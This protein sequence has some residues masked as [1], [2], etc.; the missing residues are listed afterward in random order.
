MPWKD[1]GVAVSSPQSARYPSWLQRQ[2]DPSS[3]SFVPGGGG[4]VNVTG[5]N[6]VTLGT[7]ARAERAV[8][9]GRG[10]LTPTPGELGG[11]SLDWWIG[12]EDRW[13]LPSQEVS[14]RQ[15]LVDDAPVVETSM[16]IRGGDVVHRA[17]AIAAEDGTPWV[18]V[19]V[20]NRTSSAVAV[21]AV[22]R[23]WGPLGPARVD[24]VGV[25]GAWVVVDGRA[26]VGLPQPP[27][28]TYAASATDATSVL[29]AAVAASESTPSDGAVC[30][31]GRAELAAV[32]PLPHTLVA[33]F[34]VPL[35]PAAP[36]RGRVALPDLPATLP[37]AAQVASGWSAQAGRGVAVEVPDATIAGALEANRRHLL[38]VAAGEDLVT[39]P[40]VAD[41][42][43]TWASVLGA[44]DGWG[45]GD[46]VGDVVAG[47]ED[48]QA[49]DGHFLGN[50]RR[51]DATGAALVALGD[52]VA[53]DADASVAGTLAPAVA[54]GATWIDRRAA[55]RRRRRD[56]ATIGLPPDGE[57]PWWIGG[58]GVTFHAAWWSLAGLRSAARILDVGGEPD[59]AAEARR[60]AA[61]LAGALDAALATEVARVGGGVIPA[62][63]GRP[64]DPG[65]VGVLDAVVL[66]VLDPDDPRVDATVELLRSTAQHELG[67]VVTDPAAGPGPVGWSPALTAR[68][69]RVELARG[70]D[71]AVERLRWLARAASSS[72]TWPTVVHP[73]TGGGVQGS[74]HDPLATAEFLLATR[75]LLVRWDVDDDG[76]VRLQFAP[77]VPATWLGAPWEVHDLPTPAG[78]LGY[79]V[80]WH[81]GRPALLWEIDGGRGLDV[82][83]TAPGLDPAWSSTARSGEALLA[84]PATAPVSAP[85]ADPAPDPAADPAPEG[86]FQ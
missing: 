17:F 50:D 77:V 5:R 6:W 65:I 59:G 35:A 73:V 12:A 51:V 76:T 16:R 48:R 53:L 46:E 34:A 4:A 55:S 49:L 32:V 61:R 75:D 13:Y 69:A 9:D 47:F 79:A 2:I 14:V 60:C 36:T 25:D 81:G 33:R 20:E 66:G 43:T 62:G 23:P 45:F 18:V 28:R 3:T 42:F 64:I 21:A 80:R 31:D 39:W 10:M 19:E 72:V 44:L 63:P 58:A 84:A 37:T 38:L 41:D 1:G 7:L 71:I 29:D 83:I 56:A 67:V 68:L 86:G 26:A 82:L 70:E 85:A 22:I 74:G 52:H 40:A 54:R 27:F 30:A 15:R 57:A 24:A 78:R 11:W 8:V